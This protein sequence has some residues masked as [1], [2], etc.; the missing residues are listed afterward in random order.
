MLLCVA[1]FPVLPSGNWDD[2]GAAIDR[3][4]GVAPGA[5]PTLCQELLR[6]VS[7]QAGC[8]ASDALRVA[9]TR[10][11]EA[12]T[13]RLISLAGDEA[14]AVR[15]SVEQ[16]L[17]AADDLARGEA[18]AVSM[19]RF[20]GLARTVAWSKVAATRAAREFLTKSARHIPFRQAEALWPLIMELR[21]RWRVH[22]RRPLPS[23]PTQVANAEHLQDIAFQN[24]PTS[25]AIGADIE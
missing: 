21:S 18:E 24:E 8:T 20:T 5:D 9:L 12:V 10:L 14:G 1:A 2:L 6:F 25:L 19:E 16:A 23:P 4:A 15:Q 13:P 7:R 17:R 11:F 3:T 22:G